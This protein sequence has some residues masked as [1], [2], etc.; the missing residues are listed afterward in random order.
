LQANTDIW[1]EHLAF[2]FRVNVCVRVRN[3]LVSNR[4]VARKSATDPREG[5][6][7]RNSAVTK[8][9][10]WPLLIVH[11]GQDRDPFLSSRRYESPPSLQPNHITHPYTLQPWSCWYMFIK[12]VGIHLED[13]AI[14]HKTTISTLLDILH[15]MHMMQ[16]V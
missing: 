5:K 2:I 4:Q 11:L 10:L 3:R 14:A 1:E 15:S 9:A 13:G 6:S 8:N 16:V 12:N 7:K